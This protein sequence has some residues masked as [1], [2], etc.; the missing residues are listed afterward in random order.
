MFYSREELEIAP[1]EHHHTKLNGLR[2]HF[3]ILGDGP[4]VL[5][6]HG[7]PDL[8]RGWRHQMLALADS[9]FRA[10]A[11]DMRGFGETE[12]PDDPHSYTAVDLVGDMVALLDYLA[13]S[14]AVIVGHDWGATI[15]WA[16][17][18]LRPDRF[19]GVVALSVPYTPRGPV[20]LP[21]M[22]KMQAPPDFYM[23]YFLEP[24]R[25]EV[26]LDADPLTFLR[27]IFYTNSGNYSSDH[28]HT[29]RLAASG[30]LTDALDDPPSEMD[31]FDDAELDVYAAQ[32][33]AHG[34]RG[35]LNTYRSL[36]RSWHL[37]A[38]TSD[39]TINV[40]VLFIG[41][42][43]DIVLNFPGMRQAVGKMCK[44]LP[45]AEPPV[46]LANAG[47]FMHLELPHETNEALMR[48]MTRIHS[49]I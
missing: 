36:D 23:L 20:S 13:V 16:A 26:E 5:L 12:A 38:I 21:A 34:F 47:H 28:P 11:P 43:R 9:G 8:W 24:G 14:D 35:P 37:L 32:Y 15:A 29:M 4:A 46:I 18:T 40:P 45:Q 6:C 1:F 7:F 41:G 33:G 48:F 22:L 19:K 10:I 42:E 3:V 27:R 44:L 17:A 39:L 49:N 31:W 25:A 2:Y 30:R